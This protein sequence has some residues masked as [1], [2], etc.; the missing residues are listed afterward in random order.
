MSGDP[1]AG[2]DVAGI[3]PER[4]GECAPQAVLIRWNPDD[5]DMVGH[6]AIGPDFGPEAFAAV[7]QQIEIEPVVTLIE[8]GFLPWWPRWVT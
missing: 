7:G 2:V 1:G 3:A 4:V 5:V 8:E 6:Q